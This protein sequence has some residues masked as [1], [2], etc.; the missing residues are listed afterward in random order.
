MGAASRC[1]LLNSS[2]HQRERLQIEGETRI[3]DKTATLALSQQKEEAHVQGHI[4][5][6]RAEETEEETLSPAE[7]EWFTS[8]SKNHSPAEAPS[9]PRPADGFA[10]DRGHRTTNGSRR[11]PK[12]AREYGD[13]GKLWMPASGGTHSAGSGPEL[14]LA[15]ACYGFLATGVPTKRRRFPEQRTEDRI[16]CSLRRHRNGA[17]SPGPRRKG[18]W[19]ADDELAPAGPD[20]QVFMLSCARINEIFIFL[21]CAE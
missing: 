18:A 13:S 21:H 17:K 2:V 12:F 5:E 10:G 3:A 15:R 1:G 9:S 11:T 6:E 14:L 20:G 4:D 16:V 8:P 7:R 19:R